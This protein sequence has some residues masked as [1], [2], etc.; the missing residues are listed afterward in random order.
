RPKLLRP[1]NRPRV[2]SRL[3]A[4]Q[5]QL[6]S[7]KKA[8]KTSAWKRFLAPE[9]AKR[10]LPP[11]PL[12]RPPKSSTKRIKRRVRLQGRFLPAKAVRNDVDIRARVH[13]CRSRVVSGHGFSRAE[14][15]QN[16]AGL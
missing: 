5:C 13:S 12:P 9:P 10:Q 14:E 2:R 3:P 4:P 7:V 6:I 15:Q 1:K 8:V 11:R 16:L